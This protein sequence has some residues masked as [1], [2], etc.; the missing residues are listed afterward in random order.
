[1]LK[2]INERY[3]E[4]FVVVC[5]FSYLMVREIVNTH[6]LLLAEGLFVRITVHQGLH[7]AHASLNIMQK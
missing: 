1:M 3:L 5:M 4:H 7:P 2:T 6:G